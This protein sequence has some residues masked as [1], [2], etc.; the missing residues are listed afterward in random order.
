VTTEYGRDEFIY[1]KDKLVEGVNERIDVTKR[2]TAEVLEFKTHKELS[3]N[4]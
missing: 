1:G 3:H 4:K 2:Q